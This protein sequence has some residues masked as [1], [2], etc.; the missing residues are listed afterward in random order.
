VVLEAPEVL[1]LGVLSELPLV[2]PEVPLVLPVD[3]LRLE[4]EVPDE[5]TFSE[6]AEYS[7]REILPSLFLSS[8]VNCASCGVPA[9]S[10]REMLP[11]LFLSIDENSCAP[12][13][14][15]AVPMADGDDAEVVVDGD[16]ADLAPVVLSVPPAVA[17]SGMAKAVAIMAA[18]RVL[19]FMVCVS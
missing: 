14:V 6:A 19:D 4:P 10:S 11:S 2:L 13:A 16:D 3:P 7:L 1:L 9:A 17:A 5:A 12:P 15:L 18:K 8:W